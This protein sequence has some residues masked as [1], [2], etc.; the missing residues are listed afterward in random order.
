MKSFRIFLLIALLSL[1]TLTACERQ[2]EEVVGD[3]VPA[4]T[5]QEEGA[6]EETTEGATAET[7]PTQEGE[8]AASVEEPTQSTEETVI[9]VGEASPTPE[10]EEAAEP[11]PEPEATEVAVTEPTPTP[12]AA[13]A[14]EQPAETTQPEEEAATGPRVHIVQEGEWLYAIARTYGVSPDAIIAANNLQPPYTVYPGQEL[15][16]PE[17]TSDE[18]QTGDTTSEQRI[19]VVQE[20]EWLY[21]IARTY[22]VSPDAIIAANN[23]Q[24]PYTV[25][26]GQ[27]LIIPT[28]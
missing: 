17:A 13:A 22:G 16:I 25:Y 5:T 18:T 15:I 20:G 4:E 26:P 6:T 10:A 7:P 28:P 12:E 9:E 27:K 2:R 21:A 3:L 24:P 14:E 11:T 1:F 8:V 19:H 23:L